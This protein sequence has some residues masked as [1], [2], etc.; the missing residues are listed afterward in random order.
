[1]SS[2]HEDER[3]KSTS[4]D[5]C[6]SCKRCRPLPMGDSRTGNR[7]ETNLSQMKTRARGPPKIQMTLFDG[8]SSSQ[9]VTGNRGAIVPRHPSSVPRHLLDVPPHSCSFF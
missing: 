8:V 9:F 4:V 1:M 3:D 5:K 6:N 2:N 7:S